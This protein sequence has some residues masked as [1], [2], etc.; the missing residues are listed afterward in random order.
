MALHRIERLGQSSQAKIVPPTYVDH[1]STS[2]LPTWATRMNGTWTM[3]SAS[4]PI[5]RHRANIRNPRA[6]TPPEPARP[7]WPVE[8]RRPEWNG[9]AAVERPKRR[10][11]GQGE[12]DRRHHGQTPPATSSAAPQRQ[13]PSR[14]PYRAGVVAEHDQ[15]THGQRRHEEQ[16]EP[17][18]RDES[19]PD[20][21]A[22]RVACRR[23]QPVELVDEDGAP[24]PRTPRS[25]PAA[26]APGPPPGDPRDRPR[27]GS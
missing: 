1:S 20:D 17:D 27:S 25:T 2:G 3:T 9:T 8:Q 5:R 24:W 6:G 12:D 11:A 10:E 18:Q 15:D 4:G 23:Q 16:R 22:R 14:R 13:S 19:Q 26:G 21:L 7:N